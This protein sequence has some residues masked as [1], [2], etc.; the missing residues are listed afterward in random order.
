[1]IPYSVPTLFPPGGKGER[2]VGGYEDRG[3]KK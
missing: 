1:M 2:G 3:G